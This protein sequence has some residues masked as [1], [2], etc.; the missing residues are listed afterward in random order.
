M[1]TIEKW[2]WN[3]SSFDIV[4]SKTTVPWT[5]QNYYEGKVKIAQKVD[6]FETFFHQKTGLVT[7][8]VHYADCF[9][10]VDPEGP[11][12]SADVLEFDF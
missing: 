6:I 11:E 3:G 1:D 4:A 2:T 10:Y 12:G 5:Q 9:D 7:N 8:S